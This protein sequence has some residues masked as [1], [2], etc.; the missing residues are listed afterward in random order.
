MSPQYGPRY[1]RER[2]VCSRRTTVLSPVIVP[3]SHLRD[4]EGPTRDGAFSAGPSSTKDPLH[5][6]PV[7]S[8]LKH[9]GLERPW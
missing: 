5:D 3:F 4:L 9:T 2:P 1:S 6:F 8:L 7:P